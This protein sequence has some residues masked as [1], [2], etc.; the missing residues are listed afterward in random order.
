[1]NI[2]Y[3]YA[4][5]RKKDDTPYYI[6]KGKGNR[7]FCPEHL[8]SVPKDRSKIVF[9]HVGL[10]D[11]DACMLERKYI[12]LFGRKD[13][14]TGIL[15]NQTDGGTGGDT[16]KSKGYLEAKAANKF[17]TKG[18]KNTPEH[19]RK[20]SAA[21]KGRKRPPEVGRKVSAKRKGM[22]VLKAR[23]LSLYTFRHPKHG[24]IKCTRHEF[25]A[26]YGNDKDL[27]AQLVCTKKPCYRKGWIL[28]EHWVEAGLIDSAG[29]IISKPK[30]YKGK[31]YKFQHSIHGIVYCTRGQLIDTYGL[32]KD[33]LKQIFK[34]QK[35]TPRCK[36][37][38]LVREDLSLI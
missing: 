11:E 30:I 1:M 19:N 6:G 24:E 16:S 14:G 20:I 27:A 7:A 29:Q 32:A 35:L 18:M 33:A 22:I 3:V 12:K 17:S 37:W 15:L 36:G 13:L 28:V 25:N 38:R 9:Y 8:V 26:L 10:T 31:I 21:L 23:D 4:Y 5:L 2:Y 34:G